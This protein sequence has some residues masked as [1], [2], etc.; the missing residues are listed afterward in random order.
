M[1]MAASAVQ[2][3]G[4]AERPPP[5]LWSSKDFAAT[6]RVGSQLQLPRGTP[7]MNASVRTLGIFHW[8]QTHFQCILSLLK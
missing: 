2:A 1:A 6:I 5:Q 8:T 4:E 3:N 7:D